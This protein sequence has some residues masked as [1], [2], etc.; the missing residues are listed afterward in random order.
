MRETISL[1]YG[2]EFYPKV[3]SYEQLKVMQ[4]SSPQLVDIPHNMHDIA[5][6]NFDESSYQYQSAYRKVIP[7]ERLLSAPH[8]LLT[9]HGVANSAHVWVNGSHKLS[10]YC[11]YL[12]FQVDI[13]AEADLCETIEVVVLVDASEDPT[14]PPFGHVVDY[15][16]Y[17]GIYREVELELVNSVYIDNCQIITPNVIDNLGQVTANV[18]LSN[19]EQSNFKGQLTTNV[20]DRSGKLVARDRRT[21]CFSGSEWTEIVDIWCEGVVLWDLDTPN[22]YSIQLVLT[23]E[24]QSEEI[25]NFRFGFRQVEFRDEGFYLNGQQTTLIGLNRHQSFPYVGYAM[26]KSAQVRDADLLKQELGCNCVRSSHY[27]PSKHFLNRCDEI[28]LLVF[29]EIPGWQHVSDKQVWRERTLD[30]TRR[31]VMRDWNH[32]SVFIWGVRINESP[33]CHELYVETNRIARELDPTRPTGG[34][35]CIKNSELL[36]DVYTY[37]DFSHTGE[38]AGLEPPIKVAG[39]TAPYLVSEHNGH[40]F[41]TKA[42]D[43]QDRLLSHALRHARV[44]DDAFKQHGQAGAI[45]WCMFDYNTHEDFGSGDGICYHGVLDIFRE[46]KYAAGVYASQQRTTP[47]M[48]LASNT[49][50][51]DYA[52]AQFGAVHVFTNCDYVKLYKNGEYINTF[53]P[54]VAGFAYMPH[55]PIVID[56][57]IGDQ[58]AK[59]ELFSVTDA[60]QIRQLFRVITRSGVEGLTLVQKL[61]LFYRMKKNSLSE[62]DMIELFIRYIGNWGEETA[63]YRVEGFQGENR[64]ITQSFGKSR[65]CSLQLQSDQTTLY[66]ADTYDVTRVVVRVVDEDHRVKNYASNP[67]QI[68]T[69]ESLQVLGP[70]TVSLNAGRVAFWVRTLGKRGKGTVTVSTPQFESKTI[71]LDLV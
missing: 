32:P 45:G 1:N 59:N 54:D 42:F 17:G 13:R 62:Q 44:I 58:L 66:H 46:P 39:K 41:P 22:L 55:A 30:N 53:Y 7:S 15:L 50:N 51:G 36:E 49:K 21:V 64:V 38:N 69:S 34:V 57:F 6:N 71:T 8:A 61:N 47:V 67:I 43:S 37:N 23:G 25:Q 70:E 2:W 19:F 29:N 9:F 31:M 48:T 60:E 18:M 33:D 35:R 24:N 3:A 68:T 4:D 65:V 16:T 40:M 14:V 12:P 56:D 5:L 20:I 27:P 28:G 63:T 10:N 11:G 52:N 26:P